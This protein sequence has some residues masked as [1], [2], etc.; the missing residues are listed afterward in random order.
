MRRL[1]DWVW[2]NVWRRLVFGCALYVIGVLQCFDGHVV[3][4]ALL[5]FIG[6]LPAVAAGVELTE[7][8]R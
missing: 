3:A 7:K 8:V 6:F 5:M 2:R 1:I 4:G